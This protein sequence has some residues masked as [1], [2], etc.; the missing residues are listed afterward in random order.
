MINRI[1]FALSCFTVVAGCSHAPE[2]PT[3]PA[4][5]TIETTSAPAGDEMASPGGGGV[6]L[7]PRA[8]MT[9]FARGATSVDV[10]PRLL[11]TVQCGSHRTCAK[12]PEAMAALVASHVRIVDDAGEEVPLAAAPEAQKSADGAIVTEIPVAVT[13]KGS[14]KID[15]WYKLQM[16]SDQQLVLASSDL[17]SDEHADVLS[18]AP[19]D[20]PGTASVEVP[21]FT[22]SA[23]HLVEVKR[24]TDPQKP[25]ASVVL[26]FSEAVKLASAARSIE[27]TGARRAPLQGCIWSPV[28]RRC[29]DATDVMINSAVEFVFAKPVSAADLASIEVHLGGDLIGGSRTVAEGAAAAGFSLKAHGTL[30]RSLDVAVAASN[31]RDCTGAGDSVC[32]REASSQP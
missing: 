16:S 5:P 13:V 7:R 32:F 6:D 1:C 4:P 11:F 23:P 24:S 10:E 29:A 30:G 27:I 28:M 17:T 31:W 22:G 18:G 21:F 19:H 14:L 20:R 3:P 8:R 9:S 12:D 2:E 26:T 25:L 15:R